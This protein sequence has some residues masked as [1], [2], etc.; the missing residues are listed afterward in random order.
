MQ[1]SARNEGLASLLRV[2][3]NST[4][5]GVDAAAPHAFSRVEAQHR[6]A[7]APTNDGDDVNNRTVVKDRNSGG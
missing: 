5:H 3:N 4:N 6:E 2:N 7:A 1:H